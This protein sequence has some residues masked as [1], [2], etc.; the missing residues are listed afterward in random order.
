MVDIATRL[1]EEMENQGW[2]PKELSIAAG[3]NPHTVHNF[4][5]GKSRKLDKLKSISGVLGVNPS[6]L[7]LGDENATGPFKNV[8][9]YTYKQQASLPYD[10]DLYRESIKIVEEVLAEKG[11]RVTK[12]LVDYFV[13]EIYSYA[14]TQEQT[15]VNR[16]YANGVI[17][18]AIK[19]GMV[20]KKL[21]LEV[22]S[23]KAE[24]ETQENA[25]LENSALEE[26]A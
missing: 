13:N 7:L 25:V 4:L 20:P 12:E 6:Y 19:V 1:R 21:R 24:S 14:V 3:L 22:V 10:G 11:Y 8:S 15:D 23:P 2:K 26:A 17:S 5:Y 18:Y 16:D 9:S